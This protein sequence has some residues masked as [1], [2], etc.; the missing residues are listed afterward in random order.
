MFSKIHQL[1]QESFTFYSSQGLK[2][3]LNNK[4]S[5]LLIQ[6][7]K[8]GVC[9]LLTTIIH[10]IF[11]YTLGST[12]NPAIGEHIAR[13]IKETRTMLNNVFAFIL[14]N[15]IAFKLNVNFVF[16]S[17]RHSKTKEIILFF[18]VSGISFFSGLLS[19]PLVFD[20]IDTNRGIEHLANGAFVVSSALVNFICR[21]YIIFAK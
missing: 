6:I 9:G 2:N 18:T 15:T 21:K 8:Y 7:I 17:G 12:I 10:I 20:L 13:D 4:N 1:I 3:C 14:S 19:I 16:K 11:V 5:P